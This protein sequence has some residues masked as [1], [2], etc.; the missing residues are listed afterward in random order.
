MAYTN[1]GQAS[2]K[3]NFYHVTL[4]K[5]GKWYAVDVHDGKRN[6]FSSQEQA[7][8]QIKKWAHESGEKTNHV[9]IHGE[10]NRIVEQRTV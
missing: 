8:E 4:H 1:K 10:G 7:F 3:S 9:Y 5:D 6:A 2:E